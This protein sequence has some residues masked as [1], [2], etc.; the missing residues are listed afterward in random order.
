MRPLNYLLIDNIYLIIFK[1]TKQNYKYLFKSFIFFFKNY[2][3]LLKYSLN[4]FHI[5]ILFTLLTYR[6]FD[7]Y[8]IYIYFKNIIYFI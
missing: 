4:I 5:H 6:S 2:F 8:F 3:N 1:N 7:I